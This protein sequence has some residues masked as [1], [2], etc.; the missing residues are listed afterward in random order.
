MLSAEISNWWNTSMNLVFEPE[1]KKKREKMATE[2][3]SVFY[4]SQ[5]E[6]TMEMQKA[7]QIRKDGPPVVNW[8]P[9][10]PKLFH[11]NQN[12]HI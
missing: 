10:G 4:R 1:A 2:K 6:I 11:E 7:C 12:Y 9:A 3:A 5:R 8:S